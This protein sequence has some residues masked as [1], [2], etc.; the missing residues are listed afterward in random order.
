M[1]SLVESEKPELKL[2]DLDFSRVKEL[3]ESASTLDRVRAMRST[4]RKKR[5]TRV[6]LSTTQESFAKSP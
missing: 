6:D 3:G 2:V 4:A 5:K 1:Y